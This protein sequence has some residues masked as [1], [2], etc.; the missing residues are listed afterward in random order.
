MI[1]QI[2]GFYIKIDAGLPDNFN[3][4]IETIHRKIIH[5]LPLEGE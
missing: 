1:T 5:I 3:A 4:K 2:P